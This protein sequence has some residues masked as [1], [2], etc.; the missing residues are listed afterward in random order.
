MTLKVNVNPNFSQYQI[1]VHQDAGLVEIDD[2]GFHA[3]GYFRL[4][5]WHLKC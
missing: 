1:N 3:E 5:S 4:W 2:A